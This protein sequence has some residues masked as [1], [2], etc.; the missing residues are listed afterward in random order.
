MNTTEM[1]IARALLCSGWNKDMLV[2]AMGEEASIN[3]DRI[4]AE[5]CPPISAKQYDPLLAL[6]VRGGQDINTSTEGDIEKAF[7][8]AFAQTLR[9]D[10][11]WKHSATEFAFSGEPDRVRVHLNL[12]VQSPD[13]VGGQRTNQDLWI[14]NRNTKWITK[15]VHGYLRDADG[16]DTT[17]FNVSDIDPKPGRDPE[18]LV[19]ATRETD[20]KSAVLTVGNRGKL[21]F[22]AVL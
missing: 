9:A 8:V 11:G 4:T 12:V 21:S 10:D 6:D 5:K 13:R 14:A 20:I 16:H 3:W 22:E 18:Y 15:A 1:A 2:W 7:R 19:L 17:S